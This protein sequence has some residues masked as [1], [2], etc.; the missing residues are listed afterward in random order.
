MPCY[1]CGGAGAALVEIGERALLMVM[2]MYVMLSHDGWVRC[3]TWAKGNREAEINAGG[4][5]GLAFFCLSLFLLRR[6]CCIL[7]RCGSIFL[8]CW[9]FLGGTRN[10]SKLNY[11]NVIYA[12]N[13]L[14]C[15]C[16]CAAGAVRTDERY[17]RTI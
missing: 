16:W 5:V 7:V 14:L 2:M 6:F 4:G 17:V 9:L 12:I 1:G 11:N 13:I 10:N 3:H 15:S 8:F